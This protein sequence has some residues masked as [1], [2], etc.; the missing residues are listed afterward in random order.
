M[1]KLKTFVAVAAVAALAATTGTA[2]AQ[3]KIDAKCH[4]TIGKSVYKYQATLAKNI[5]GCHK[6]RGKA[7]G[8]TDCNDHT[9]ND[10]KGKAA[11]ARGKAVASITG[12]CI[13]GPDPTGNDN[14]LALYG[15]CPSPAAASDDGGLTDGIDTF[16]ELA[17]C[18]LDLSE[19]YMDRVGLEV[20]GNPQTVPLTSGKAKCQGAIGKT[21]AKL[22]KTAGGTYTKCQAGQEKLGNGLDYDAS[23]TGAAGDTKGKFAGTITAMKAAIDGSCGVDNV[24]TQED[25]ADIGA[26]GQSQAAM[27]ACAVDRVAVP[28]ARGLAAASLELPSQ[29]TSFADVIINAGSGAKLSMTNLESGTSGL[30]HGVDVG[31]LS[32]GGVELS[33]CD[34]DCENCAITHDPSNGNCRC[35]SDATIECTTINGADD[36]CGGGTCQCMFGPPLSISSG[37]TPVCVVNR[38]AEEFNGA[39]GVVGEYSVLTRTRALVHLGI[40]AL[41]PCP[42]CDDDVC[43]GG[44]RNGL[45]CSVDATHPDFGTSSFDCPPDPGQNVSGAGLNL[46]LE[47]KSGTDSITAAINNPAQC[48]A[49][50]CHCGECSLDALVGC[51]EDADCAAVGAGTCTNTT[52]TSEQNACDTGPA[53]CVVT[54]NPDVGVCDETFDQFCDGATRQNGGFIIPCNVQGDCDALDADCEGGDCGTC[55]ALVP[56]PCFLLKINAEGTPGIFN[57]EGISVFCSAATANS[58]VNSAGGLPGPGRVKLDFDF[59]LYC[60]DRTTVWELPSGS[61]C[62]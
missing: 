20:M 34:N 54:A 50:T 43:Q 33:G 52:H 36:A 6:T 5:V 9:A 1:T 12:K 18:V 41:Q 15:R 53:E 60:S 8:A 14:V 24:P 61:N 2:S 51:S 31:D 62:P 40:G 17:N 49:G 22:I 35:E 27:K 57:S 39:T 7:G 29:C 38:F 16:T 26:C 28:T 46:G 4:A 59:S 30:A 45:A 10:P 37:G 55:G 19:E 3:S 48:T 13:A 56:K 47:F 25:W 11:T 58:G 23:C 44:P 21:F 42:T 32:L